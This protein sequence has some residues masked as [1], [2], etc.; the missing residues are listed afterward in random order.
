VP[1]RTG[2]RLNVEEVAMPGE[3]VLEPDS[4]D[5]LQCLAYLG[6]RPVGIDVTERHLLR[7][8][9]TPG[10]EVEAPVGNDVEHG[11]A[12]GDPG[13][14]VVVEGHAHHTVADA[15]SRRT[16]SDRGEEDLRRAHMRI[17]V[18]RMVF[19]GPHAVEAHLFGEYRLLEAVPYE[20]LLPLPGRIGQL[21]FEDHR[22]LHGQGPFPWPRWFGQN[23]YS[24][25]ARRSLR[26]WG[27]SSA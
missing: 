25:S 3:F 2:R 23:Y 17:P 10:A 11:G 8:T 15:D 1:R 24:L 26:R 21:G 18:Q 16:A 5:D 6:H 4:P 19:D 27:S 20:L 22:K 9:A 7:R 14:V 13:G 12:L